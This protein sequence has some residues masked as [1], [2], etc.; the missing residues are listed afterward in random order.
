M[1]KKKSKPDFSKPRESQEN[2]SSNNPFEEELPDYRS[3]SGCR[4]SDDQ[5]RGV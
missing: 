5:E 1:A 2:Q 3:A 4:G